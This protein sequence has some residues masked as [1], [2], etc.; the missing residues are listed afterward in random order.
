MQLWM[1]YDQSGCS[2]CGK[3]KATVCTPCR[4]HRMRPRS[5]DQ[6]QV[7]QPLVSDIAKGGAH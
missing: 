5:P 6:R 2:S 4:C 3:D 7:P 1:L